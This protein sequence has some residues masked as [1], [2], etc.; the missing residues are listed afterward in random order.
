MNNRVWFTIGIPLSTKFTINITIF[1]KLKWAVQPQKYFKDSSN[2]SSFR[3]ERANSRP[4]IKCVLEFKPGL[5]HHVTS[6]L[7]DT[8]TRFSSVVP[9]PTHPSYSLNQKNLNSQHFLN[10]GKFW[11]LC[12]LSSLLPSSQNSPKFRGLQIPVTKSSEG[13]TNLSPA[14]LGWGYYRSI[15]LITLM[16]FQI[17]TI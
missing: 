7:R 16:L 10:L 2:T 13:D 4:F 3:L 15:T 5:C 1:K 11:E 14:N 12:L 17:F 8:T 9:F 6:V